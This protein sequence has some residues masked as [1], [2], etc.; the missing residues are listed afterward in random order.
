MKID[1]ISN[2]ILENIASV[3]RPTTH[4][5]FFVYIDFICLLISRINRSPE[6]HIVAT[7]IK[8]VMT[9]AERVY[10][11]GSSRDLIRNHDNVAY[12]TKLIILNA[13]QNTFI[14]N[15]WL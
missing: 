5:I 9:I 1:T 8:L 10:R 11:N 12:I 3:H 7:A 13:I 2:I 4:L 15:F 6:I 14:N